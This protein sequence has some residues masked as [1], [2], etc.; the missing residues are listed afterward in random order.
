VV[1]GDTTPTQSVIDN[2]QGCDVLIHEAYS[3]KTY[4]PVSAAAQNAATSTIRDRPCTAADRSGPEGFALSVD[5]SVNEPRRTAAS[6]VAGASPTPAGTFYACSAAVLLLVDRR[7]RSDVLST[8][9]LR[10]SRVVVV[11]CLSTG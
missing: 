7:L 9:H 4:N 3:M 6:D 1:S 5:K 8:S 11:G 2:W 10:R